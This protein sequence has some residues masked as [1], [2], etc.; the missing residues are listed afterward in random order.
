LGSWIRIRITVKSGVADPECLS[1]ILIFTHPRSRI[2]DP[3]TAK[4]ERGEKKFVVMPFLVATNFTKKIWACFQRNIELFTQKYVTKLSKDGFGIRDPR[5]NS[6]G[7]RSR[8]QK[9][10]GSRIPIRNTGK[11]PD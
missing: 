5:K 6:S 2:S 9:G 3:K 4:K 8:G 10:T 11:K 7:S 1:R